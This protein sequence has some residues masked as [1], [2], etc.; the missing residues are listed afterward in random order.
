MPEQAPSLSPIDIVERGQIKKI[1][2][3]RLLGDYAAIQKISLSV[4]ASIWSLA[5][6]VCTIHR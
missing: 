5:T 3:Y 1:G 6:L 2:R 4:K